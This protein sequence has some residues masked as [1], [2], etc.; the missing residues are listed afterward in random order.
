MYGYIKVIHRNE[1]EGGRGKASALNAG[2]KHANG[3]IILCFDT[4]YYPQVNIVEKLVVGFADQ[5]VGGVQGRVVVLNEPQNLVTRLVALERMGGYRVDQ[6]ARHVLGLV[7]QLGGTAVAIRRSL[8]ESLGGWDP[9]ILAEDTDLTFSI[10]LAGYKIL[11][12]KD[13]ES[14]EEAVESWKAYR[15]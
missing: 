13:A 7:P 3:E 1:K 10:Y 2:L 11:Y 6:H 4:D 9:S 8:L 15:K 14:Y 12:I 5:K